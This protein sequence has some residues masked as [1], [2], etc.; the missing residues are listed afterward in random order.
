MDRTGLTKFVLVL[1]GFAIDTLASSST[2][3]GAT[4]DSLA[5]ARSSYFPNIPNLPEDDFVVVVEPDF[6]DLE[7]SLIEK[8]DVGNPLSQEDAP[9]AYDNTE[10][11]YRVLEGNHFEGDIT[12]VKLD[13]LQVGSDISKNAIVHTYQMWPNGEVPYVVSSYF[14]RKQRGTIQR[15]IE[16]F[17][18]SSCIKWRPKIAQD[19]DY[20]HFLSDEGCYSRVGRA[21]G[22]QVLSLGR[23]CF[24][25]GTVIHE[26]L[27]AVGFWHEQ[28]RPDRDNFVS[29]QWQNIKRGKEDNFA[30]YSRGEVSTLDLAYDTSSVMHY[31]STA[32]SI[33]GRPTLVARTSLK[34]QLGQRRGF[35][36][37]DLEKLNKLYSCHDS[38]DEEIECV[39]KMRKDLCLVMSREDGC[40]KLVHFSLTY[41]R[42]TCGFCSQKCVDKDVRCGDWVSYGHVTGEICKVYPD[43]MKENCPKSCQFCQRSNSHQAVVIT[44]NKSSCFGIKLLHITLAFAVALL[45]EI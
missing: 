14:N 40:S 9:F 17:S 30:R 3:T 36:S 42:K 2:T 23:G 7:R 19:Q 28:S 11:E 22:G 27:H 1:F 44:A 45:W 31:D 21:G 5:Q 15:A 43:F 13:R 10:P 6:V 12:G 35:S 34:G 16:A 20:V 25:V 29:V 41:C 32:F 33:N 4:L 24:H 18:S 37:L 39:D 38:G 8:D 26:M